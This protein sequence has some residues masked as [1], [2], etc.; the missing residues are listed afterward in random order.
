MDGSAITN[1]FLAAIGYFLIRLIKQVD[2]TSQELGNL[3]KMVGKWTATIE[4][5]ESEAIIRHD[6]VSVRLNEQH[7]AIEECRRR[8]H[9]LI[10]IL[11]AIRLQGEKLGMS[12]HSDWSLG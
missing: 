9:K 1:V 3:S 6:D 5:L 8:T 4:K 11:Q 7:E 10:S 2:Q 12:F